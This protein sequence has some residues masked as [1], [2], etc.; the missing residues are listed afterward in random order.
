MQFVLFDTDIQP[1]KYRDFLERVS[2]P[3]SDFLLKHLKNDTFF[4]TLGVD[5][6]L[7]FL[8]DHGQLVGFGATTNQDFIPMPQ[9]TPWI[10]FIYVDS[11]YRG[12]GISRKIVKFLEDQL[13]SKHVKKV[14]IMTQH[15]NLYQRYGYVLQ[16][17]TE[18]SQHRTIYI[19]EKN[20]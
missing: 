7:Y 18:D 14:N 15:E 13:R 5:S 1:K 10:S 11:S 6:K 3:A 17:T 16:D 4:E 19:L 20:I 9:R 12:Q 8:E 2:W